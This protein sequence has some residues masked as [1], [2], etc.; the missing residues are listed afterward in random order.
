MHLYER[1]GG[2]AFEITRLFQTYSGSQASLKLLKSLVFCACLR[3]APDQAVRDGQAICR[4]LG[5][6]PH[7]AAAE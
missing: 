6:L 2:N 7:A 4:M 1:C 3:P 5:E